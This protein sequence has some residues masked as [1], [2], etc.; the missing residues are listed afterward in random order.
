MDLRQ[1][2]IL[3]TSFNNFPKAGVLSFLEEINYDFTP[4]LSAKV[5]LPE[6]VDKI[7]SKAI[8]ITVG[9]SNMLKGLV[10]MYCNDEETHRA[11][12][13]L[14]GVKQE[15][16]GQGIAKKMLMDAIAVAKQCRMFTIG[17]H[18]NNPIALSL[19]KKMG[20]E[21]ILGGEREYLELKLV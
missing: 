21:T 20:F 19:Y 10:V 2:L 11:Y 9:E 1:T 5:S 4:E 6:F 3:T 7:F 15:V 18:S 13:S 14:V 17:I 8:L 16:R 12:I